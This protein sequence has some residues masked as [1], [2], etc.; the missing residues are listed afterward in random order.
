MQLNDIRIQLRE[1]T[2]AAVMW[3][4]YQPWRNACQRHSFD[5]SNVSFEY[6]L[7]KA[8]EQ[9]AFEWQPRVT[10]GVACASGRAAMTQLGS[11]VLPAGC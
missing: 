8:L 10:N 11:L 7:G 1:G 4:A 6:S 5:A 9:L 3:P 2:E